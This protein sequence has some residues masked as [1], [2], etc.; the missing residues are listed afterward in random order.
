MFSKLSL[1]KEIVIGLMWGKVGP[2]LHQIDASYFIVCILNPICLP[3][4]AK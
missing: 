3:L 2:S 4:I 1:V